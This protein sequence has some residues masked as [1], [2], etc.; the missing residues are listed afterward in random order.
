[1]PTPGTGLKFLLRALHYRN[2]RLFFGGQGISLIGTWMQQITMS[3]LVYR[4]TGSPFLLGLIGFSG[5]IPTFVLAP[6]AGVFA[7]RF[8]R[9]RTLVLTQALSMLQALILAVLTFTG[10]VAVWHLVALS[11]FIGLVNALDIPV[12][13]SFVIDL[14][15]NKKDLGNAIALNSVMFNGARLLGPSIAGVLIGLFGEAVCF[16]LNGISYFAIVIALLA[17]NVRP[18]VIESSGQPFLHGLAEGARYT[19]G[20][21]PIRDIIL[22]L[23][24]VSF[25]GTSY[26]VL[27]PVFARDILHG[28]AYALGFLMGATGI[29]ALVGAVFLASRRSVRGLGR[30]LV[31]APMILGVS[32]VVFSFSRYMALSLVMMLGA[33]FGMIV[34]MASSNTVLQTIVEEDKRGRMMSFYA[35]AFMGMATFGSLLAGSLAQSL[36]APATLTI[37][38]LICCAGALVFLTRLPRIRKL[39]RPI[40]IQLG[41]IREMPSEI[42]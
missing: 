12:R 9:R 29:G 42:R 6:F 40:Y 14:V 15:E 32:L 28:G 35:M 13:Q 30:F 2:Y 3:W 1:M 7:D 8:D 24:L 34:H 21:P 19:F 37:C 26:L 4:L 16:L 22:F 25:M 31:I 20:F 38:G 10:F 11:L 41:I 36:G 17:M 5:Q 27:M 39:I 18:R 33:G 23:G